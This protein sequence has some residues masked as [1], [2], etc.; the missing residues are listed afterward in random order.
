MKYYNDFHLERRI[1]RDLIISEELYLSGI[2]DITQWLVMDLES[3]IKEE[4]RFFG[5]M[6]VYFNI[7]KNSYI[8]FNE[9]FT[10]SDC[11]IY[12]KI[13]Y[14]FKPI[15]LHE[16]KKLEQRRLSKA[17]RIVVIMKRILDL[18]EELAVSQGH[19][20]LTAMK[21]VNEI[22]TKIYD[23][24]KNNGKK[25]DL[26]YMI[27]LMKTFYE[28][29]VVGKLCVDEFGMQSEIDRVMNPKPIDSEN[30]VMLEENKG[31]ELWRG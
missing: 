22:I 17:D 23:R 12:G 1:Q 9:G 11:E 15:I 31:T 18:T 14:L 2:F 24:I 7:M 13:M 6:P 27:T 28:K 5:I 8:Q 26:R 19:P 30:N 10:D 3:F 29:G 16:Y 20:K 25:L 21:Q 4:G